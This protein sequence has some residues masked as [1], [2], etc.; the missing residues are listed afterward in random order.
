M[1]DFTREIRVYYYTYMFGG[2]RN[3]D[4]SSVYSRNSQIRGGFREPF[5]LPAVK[6]NERTVRVK[7]AG[8]VRVACRNYTND[9]RKNNQRF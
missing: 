5:A 8:Y 3:R 6:I 1:H 2:L 4:F 9:V 7:N